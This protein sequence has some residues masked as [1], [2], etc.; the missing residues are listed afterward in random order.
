[1]YLTLLF[2]FILVDSIAKVKSEESSDDDDSNEEESEDDTE[3]ATA[4]KRMP[5][6]IKATGDNKQESS[7]SDS[8]SEESSSDDDDDDNNDDDDDDDEGKDANI[9]KESSEIKQQ[10]DTQV[11]QKEVIVKG[12][13]QGNE[14]SSS[15]E[16]DS[17]EEDSDE[18]SDSESSEESEEE[19]EETKKVTQRTEQVAKSKEV[20]EIDTEDLHSELQQLKRQK[21]VD[22]KYKQKS[23][24]VRH[25]R[26]ERSHR[27]REQGT[28]DARVHKERNVSEKEKVDVKYQRPM[29]KSLS[30]SDSKSRPHEKSRSA[31]KVDGKQKD[32]RDKHKL[33]ANAKEITKSKSDR[34]SSRDKYSEMEVDRKRKISRKDSEKRKTPDG[35]SRT[36]SKVRDRKDHSRSRRKASTSEKANKDSKLSVDDVPSSKSKTDEGPLLILTDRER[37]QFSNEIVDIDSEGSSVEDEQEA[38]HSDVEMKEQLSDGEHG[39]EKE[40]EA[41]LPPY[42]PAVRGCRNVEEFQWLNRIEEGTYGVVYRAKDKRT[43]LTKIFLFFLVLFHFVL[44][45]EHITLK[46]HSS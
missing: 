45:I 24:T 9:R 38:A 29:E 19:E 23:K 1:M 17:S 7:E 28:S 8:G 26:D 15:E 34:P 5:I 31:D 40:K 10:K 4:T 44:I 3:T 2:C 16:E 12:K 30:R 27:R 32:G 42:Y 43:G 21:S 6:E 39:D 13:A 41:K 37:R 11:K 33:S 14:E 22:E 25:H 46:L 35:A 20:D 36:E 18:E